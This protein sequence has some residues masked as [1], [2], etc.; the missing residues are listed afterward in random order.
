M[1]K[2]RKGKN[3]LLIVAGDFNVRVGQTRNMDEKE[4]AG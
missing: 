2:E 4:I 3:R 1:G